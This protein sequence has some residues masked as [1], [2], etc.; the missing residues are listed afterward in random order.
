MNILKPRTMTFTDIALFKWS[1]ILAGVALGA[2]FAD[3]FRKRALLIFLLGLFLGIKP[4][5]TW[6]GCCCDKKD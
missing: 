4:M 5:I 6:T 3:K 1:S 2:L